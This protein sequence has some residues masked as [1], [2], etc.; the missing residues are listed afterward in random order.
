MLQALRGGRE[1][2]GRGAA[3]CGRGSWR[4]RREGKSGGLEIT[5]VIQSVGSATRLRRF[6]GVPLGK[7]TQPLLASVSHLLS[8]DDNRA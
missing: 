3:E 6:P 2:W 8:G 7:L 5:H 4:R 1:G